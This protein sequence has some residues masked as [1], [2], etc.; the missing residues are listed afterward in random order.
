[1]RVRLIGEMP[2][3]TVCP[4]GR[5]AIDDIR[6]RPAIRLDRAEI[7]GF[8]KGCSFL[9]SETFRKTD[10]TTERF[11]HMLPRADRVRAT[12][13]RLTRPSRTNARCLE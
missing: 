2:S 1:M 9:R 11:E 3:G 8:G 6:H 7:P 5:Q 12:N 4:H 10:I 13:S